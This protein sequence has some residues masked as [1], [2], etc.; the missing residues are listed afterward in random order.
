LNTLPD[1]TFNFGKH[2]GRRVSA[3]ALS[4]PTYLLWLAT[5]AAARSDQVLW[6][7]LK[8]HLLVAADNIEQRYQQQI[9]EAEA[10]AQRRRQLRAQR[11]AERDAD[12]FA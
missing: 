7:A 11:Q 9:A 2:A 8:A 4:H 3:V 10:L 1:A 5:T 6:R 12:A